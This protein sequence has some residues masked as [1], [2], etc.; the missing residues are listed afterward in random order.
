MEGNRIVDQY[1]RSATRTPAAVD[2]QPARG[3]DANSDASVPMIDLIMANG[4]RLALPYHDLRSVMMQGD[5]IVMEFADRLITVRGR[6]FLP[7]Y[8]ALQLH[9]VRRI[10]ASPDGFDDGNA[11]TWI[12]TMS[13]ENASGN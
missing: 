7:L 9:L 10:L 13:V 6:S 5:L 4:D 12:E 1:L 2:A 11:S 3:F 8:N